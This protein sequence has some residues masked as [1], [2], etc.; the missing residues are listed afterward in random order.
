M[1]RTISIVF[2]LVFTPDHAVATWS[3]VAA[4]P[5][6][7]EVGGAVATCTPWSHYVLDVVPGKGVIVTQAASNSAARER[8]KLLIS[9][10]K[11]ATQ[12]ITA[13]S[14]PAFD[15]THSQQ[16]HGVVVLDSTDTS[17]GYT[18]S[19]TEPYTSDIQDEFTSV[20]GNILVGPQVLTASLLAYQN[21]SKDPSNTLADR[22]LLALEAG[23]ANGG[24]RR[25]GEQTAISAYLVVSKPTDKSNAPAIRIV[26]P[27][28][29]RGGN[30]AVNAL[31]KAYDAKT[32]EGN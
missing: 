31:R 12:V 21:S 3:I 8:G 26:A 25:C 32:S 6:T 7:G 20:Q 28:Q 30:N 27:V 17:A 1:I 19:L 29:Y 2:V 23:S 24:D 22:L 4:D 14:D 13:I 9:Q 11:S 18:G 5:T 16:Q 10:G 15:P